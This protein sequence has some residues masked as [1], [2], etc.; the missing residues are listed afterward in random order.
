[1]SAPAAFAAAPLLVGVAAGLLFP[2]VYM[3]GA[4]TALAIAW[5][6]ACAALIG[7]RG[8]S[9]AAAIA[10]GCIAAGAMIGARAQQT[11]D[12]PALIDWFEFSG[13]AAGDPAR[14]TGVL[15]ED[16]ARTSSGVSLALDVTGVAAGGNRRIV[17]GGAHVS[18][19][20]SLGFE[21]AREW[22]AGR[23][24]SLP[25]VLRVPVDY[26]DP[27]VPSDRARLARQGTV[28]LGST[29]SGALV[30]MVSRGGPVSEAAAALRA[31]VR[32]ATADAVGHW[33]GRS[34]GVVT[35]IVIGDRTGLD[36]DDERRLQDAG[37]YHVIAISGENVALLIGMIVAL[38]RGLRLPIRGTAA[39]SILLLLFYG[40]LT[41]LAPSVLRATV[42]GVVYLAARS[43]DHRGSALNAL[44]VAA[45]FAAVTAPLTVFDPGFL[46]SF[47]ATLAILV[48]VTRIR[49]SAVPD[50]TPG[51]LRAVGRW[52]WTEGRALGA[53][54]LCA[55]VALMPIAA[56]LFGRVTF[57]GLVLNFA[58]IPLMSIIEFAGLAAVPLDA[59]WRAPALACGWIA[60]VAT[61][62]LIG[63]AS[64][65]DMAPWL[66][67]DVPAPALWIMLVW[68][69]G[70]AVALLTRRPRVRRLA[71]AAIALAGVAIVHAP[72]AAT[73]F[74][75]PQIPG[76][77]TRI[78]VLDVGQGDAT[79]V[80]PAGASPLLVDAGGAPGS[81]F[82]LGRRV[83]VPAC[84][85]FDVRHLGALVLTHGDPDHIGG[86]PAVIRALAPREIWEGI[87]VPRDRA[88]EL[89]QVQ[90]A[91]A[92]IPW[93]DKR[94]GQSFTLG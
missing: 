60:H 6:A 43:I 73:A 81:S 83:T 10:V 77:W 40:Y 16:A 51:R 8:A 48:A 29:K 14:V 56:R 91:T 31:R 15:R 26:G 11:A 50:R 34:A 93:I 85:A 28:L 53:A 78:A 64:L 68:Y 39:A 89:L 84:W 86:A 66:V 23:T 75:T 49:P 82:D 5:I 33:S 45:A 7:R 24:V 57:A 79:L 74:R 37:T 55:E 17:D 94:S 47:G 42:A 44:S 35:A 61:A 38:G 30:S 25:A 46:L 41:G 69:G 62:A 88:L 58:A 9:A 2:S 71:A 54:T 32:A 20:G 65:V 12:R 76:G 59:I 22:R 21:M 92:H 19:S 4:V 36:A 70:W 90:A 3:P 87:P 18:V 13:A 1:M 67:I 52:I 80:W 72:P 27:G 63:S